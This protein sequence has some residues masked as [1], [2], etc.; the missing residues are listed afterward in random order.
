MELWLFSA[1]TLITV[2]RLI[3]AYI[4]WNNCYKVCHR[5]ICTSS[6]P[7]RSPQ[8]AICKQQLMVTSNFTRVKPTSSPVFYE[9]GFDDFLLEKYFTGHTLKFHEQRENLSSIIFYV[10]RALT[11]FFVFIKTTGTL[12]FD[13]K[14]RMWI[15]IY[16]RRNTSVESSFLICFFVFLNQYITNVLGLPLPP[17]FC[18]YDTVR[19][20]RMT[21]GMKLSKELSTEESRYRRFV[22]R[23]E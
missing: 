6:T 4:F 12:W 10:H 22:P 9:H 8:I 18:W 1:G 5:F 17:S 23:Y 3:F 19:G 11:V 2:F 16:S 14:Y 13:L 20:K 15:Y 21:T 7:E